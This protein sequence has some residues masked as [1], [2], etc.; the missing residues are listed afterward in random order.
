MLIYA[1]ADIRSCAT[2]TELYGILITLMM[3]IKIDDWNTIFAANIRSSGITNFVLINQIPMVSAIIIV[4]IQIAA[5]M[6][7][8]VI[9]TLFNFSI[10][11]LPSSY[12]RNLCEEDTIAE[13][14]NAIMVMT[15]P[16]TL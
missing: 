2:I 4:T 8:E 10:S 3:N 14:R 13:L 6:F 5:C 16:T 12:E 9:K 11:F 15:P 7:I 1:K